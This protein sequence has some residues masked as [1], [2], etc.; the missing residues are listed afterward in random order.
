MNALAPIYRGC[1]P[2]FLRPDVTDV[3]RSK[4]KEWGV[5]SFTIVA[6]RLWNKLTLNIHTARNVNMFKSKLKTHFF[7][8]VLDCN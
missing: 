7:S 8:L 1:G 6:P 4:S 3:P 2:L 5:S